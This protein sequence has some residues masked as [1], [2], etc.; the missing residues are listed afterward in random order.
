MKQ[1]WLAVPRWF[2]WLTWAVILWCVYLSLSMGEVYNRWLLE[3]SY[4]IG[5]MRAFRR[6]MDE[7]DE[8]FR[9]FDHRLSVLEH[10]LHK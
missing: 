9:S 8:R 7:S 5:E 6:L 10:S 2:Y 4:T 3:Q 1:R